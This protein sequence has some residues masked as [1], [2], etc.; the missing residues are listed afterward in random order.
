MRAEG[1]DV[2][3]NGLTIAEGGGSY[4]VEIVLAPDGGT[5]DGTVVDNDEKPAAGATVVLIA[6]PKLRAR[7]DSFHEFTADR[8]GR[9]H[10]ENVR[11]G[12]Y[13]LVA[14]DDVEPDAWFD[15]EFLKRFEAQGES[16]TLPASGHV[17]SQLHVR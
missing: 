9:F 16:V 11:P 5:V 7:Y 14:W 2:F 6:E 12:E 1:T 17:S 13:K 3:Q 15:P 10:F 4:D 8:Q